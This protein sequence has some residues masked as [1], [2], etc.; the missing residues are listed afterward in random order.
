MELEGVLTR[1]GLATRSAGRG[2]VN[3]TPGRSPP[4]TLLR[5]PPCLGA[6][7]GPLRKKT[8]GLSR[9]RGMV[10]GEMDKATIGSG[11]QTRAGPPGTHREEEG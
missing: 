6:A 2:G 3:E 9:P 4:L 8:S 11:R 1:G 7:I 10:G 5:A